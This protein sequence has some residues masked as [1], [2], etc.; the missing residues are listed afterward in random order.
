MALTGSPEGPPLPAPAPIASAAQGALLALRALAGGA[1]AGG[2]LDAAGCLGERAAVF[3]FERRGRISPGGS[4]RLVE[5]ADGWLAVNLARASDR[6]LVPAWLEVE[7]R[8]DIWSQVG[9]GVASRTSRAALSRARLMGL[10]VAPVPDHGECVPGESKSWLEMT[11]GQENP[12]GRPARRPVVLDLSSLWAGPL[13]SHLLGLAGAR[14]IKLESLERP[15]GARSGAVRFFD[16]L[17]AGKASIALE[18]TSARD[19][20]VLERLLERVDIVIES[21]RPRALAQ[22]GIVAEEWIARRAGLSWLS[23]TGYGRSEPEGSWVAFGDDAAAAAGLP[24]ATSRFNARLRGTPPTP[25]FCGD[26]IADPLSGL[27]AAPAVLASWLSGE[28]RLL[29][30]SLCGVV[31]HVMRMAHGPPWSREATG[32]EGEV[33]V[34]ANGTDG[35]QVRLGDETQ[36]VEPPR[37]RPSASHA[38]ALGADTEAVLDSLGVA[39]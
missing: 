5:T 6:E 10:P 12:Q 37:V 3:G 38:P 35:W 28:S 18:F 25:M 4:C 22:L 27:Y 17:N 39:R 8:A 13:C 30:V 15:D 29:D 34:E 31:Q 23:I 2:D 16:L 20:G 7:P 21:A 1:W 19:R 9:A 36:R 26:A 11:R 14:V 32:T 33:F 24:W